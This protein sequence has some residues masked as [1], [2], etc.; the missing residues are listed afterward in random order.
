MMDLSASEASE[1]DSGGETDCSE[2][3]SEGEGEQAPQLSCSGTRFWFCV[4]RQNSIPGDYIFS[5]RNYSHSRADLHAVKLAEIVAAWTFQTHLRAIEFRFTQARLTARLIYT[6][7]LN[8][9]ARRSILVS[10]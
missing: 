10:P 6:Q 1:Y 4:A 7:S 9:Q 3:E 5:G 2:S 8:N